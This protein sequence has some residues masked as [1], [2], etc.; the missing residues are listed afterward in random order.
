MTAPGVISKQVRD[1]V[2]A[3]LTPHGFTTNGERGALARRR[4]ASVR[5]QVILLTDISD[6]DGPVWIT[7]NLRVQAVQPPATPGNRP[8]P[9]ALN[10]NIGYLMPA[11]NW[12]QWSFSREVFDLQEAERLASCIITYGLPWLARFESSEAIRAELNMKQPPGFADL[13][14]AALPPPGRARAS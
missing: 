11:R 8:S 2:A 6:H 9:I 13:R 14:R 12:Q 5:D 3:A 1:V 10:W 4:G 7:A